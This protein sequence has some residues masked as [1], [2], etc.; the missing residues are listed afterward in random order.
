MR[1][2]IDL[3]LIDQKIEDNWCNVCD[4]NLHDCDL[5][6]QCKVQRHKT[7]PLLLLLT[8]VLYIPEDTFYGLELG[9]HAR[10][11]ETE[12]SLKDLFVSDRNSSNNF[13]SV[14]SGLPGI[15]MG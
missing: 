14:C 2:G 11:L 13:P 1:F 6:N 15:V 3:M 4:I 10:F 8:L 12:Q 5:I 9:I 7:D